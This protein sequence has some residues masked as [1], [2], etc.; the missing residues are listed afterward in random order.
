VNT[1]SPVEESIRALLQGEL[2]TAG[3]KARLDSLS[4]ESHEWHATICA[5]SRTFEIGSNVRESLFCCETIN[6]KVMPIFQS[7]VTPFAS[8][9]AALSAAVRAVKHALEHPGFLISPPPV[10]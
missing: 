8:E 7:G 9:R 10:I 2:Q 3:L 6:G 5:G 1:G 4:F